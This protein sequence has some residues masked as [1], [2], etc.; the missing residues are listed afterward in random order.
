MKPSYGSEISESKFDSGISYL[1]RLDFLQRK[2]NDFI[3]IKEYELAINTIIVMYSE[4]YSEMDKEERNKYDKNICRCTKKS[5][6]Q[7][8]TV[9]AYDEQAIIETY[10]VLKEVIARHGWINPK[11]A[12]PRFSVLEDG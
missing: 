12:D 7:Y 1:Q 5:F 8:K 4:L 10:I 6:K 3:I 11:K 2:I 9:N